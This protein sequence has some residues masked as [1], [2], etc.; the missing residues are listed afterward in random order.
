MAACAI[1]G[2]YTANRS[3]TFAVPEVIQFDEGVAA[4]VSEVVEH[5]AYWIID[6]IGE[7]AEEDEIRRKIAY[8]LP[9][10]EDTTPELEAARVAF[11][12][13]DLNKVYFRHD[14]DVKLIDKHAAEFEAA[15][16]KASSAPEHFN[17]AASAAAILMRFGDSTQLGAM[18]DLYVANGEQSH[19]LYHLCICFSRDQ[20]AQEPKFIEA[21]Q[22][23]ISNKQCTEHYRITFAE[24]L[25]DLDPTI[26][27]KAH[28]DI[29]ENSIVQSSREDSI[30]WLLK[31][32]GEDK[33]FEL[34]L[35]FLSLP[36]NHK[37]QYRCNEVIEAVLGSE[38]FGESAPQLRIKL[39]AIIE[40]LAMLHSECFH[41]VISHS[42]NEF[43]PFIERAIANP[44]NGSQL[45][46]AFYAVDAL[47]S[48]ED[49]RAL[50]RLSLNK[51][52]FAESIFRRCCQTFGKEETLEIIKSRWESEKRH[53][54]FVLICKNTDPHQSDLES[55]FF[56]AAIEAAK[57]HDSKLS[58]SAGSP[59]EVLKFAREF[60]HDELAIELS[61]QIPDVEDYWFEHSE[62]AQQY[63]DWF[64]SHFELP[65]P[66][67]L[68][69]VFD[70]DAKSDC[71]LC[72]RDEAF[73]IRH[74]KVA[75]FHAAG[76]GG[77]VDPENW[78]INGCLFAEMGSLSRGKI[79]VA[80]HDMIEGNRARLLINGRAYE[81]P[82]NQDWA[83]YDTAPASD[84]L[85]A[86]LERRRIE[87]RFFV[88][89][90][91]YGNS[92]VRFVLF[93]E[94]SKVKSF[95]DQHKEFKVEAGC[96]QYWK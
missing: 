91:A 67:T 77:V 6:S 74:F 41:E 57:Q 10:L 84:V 22:R 18:V 24:Q 80:A 75:T 64:N 69:D 51:S 12:L 14:R 46:S 40:K 16:K 53:W 25:S 54:M 68:K 9:A 27:A 50:L 33:A 78:G 79:A 95:V 56:S 37:S 8:G 90:H 86:I 71:E 45:Q 76:F 4:R 30:A 65:K 85:N 44:K 66:L 7:N 31:N 87:E 42:G 59:F 58:Y 82:L 73:W 63:L 55:D 20:T 28:L 32:T 88:F 48:D 26:L 21:L 43:E 94:P 34:A 93:A 81:F 3:T 15:A 36:E 17:H 70:A 23:Q 47:K 29:A 38:R 1:I 92:Y 96:E 35:D 60:G 89:Q 72:Y 62:E 2:W 49:Y 19:E 39:V 61:R 11:I 52:P 13:Q 5:R 83:W